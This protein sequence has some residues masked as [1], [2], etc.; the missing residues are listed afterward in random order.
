VAD[1]AE[2][3][4]DEGVEECSPAAA[5]E[6]GSRSELGQCSRR[7]RR[8]RRTAGSAHLCGGARRMKM[9][10]AGSLQGDSSRWRSWAWSSTRGQGSTAHG[11]R[12][13]A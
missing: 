8:H 4:S 13:V 10:V 11:R 5:D 6:L 7:W 3:N 9:K 2:G 1:D 12:S